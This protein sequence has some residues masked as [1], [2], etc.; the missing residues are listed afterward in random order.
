VR[1]SKSDDLI[2]L[3]INGSSAGFCLR[4]GAG[5]G[6]CNS[7][8]RRR[9]SCYSRSKWRVSGKHVGAWVDNLFPQRNK[10][11]IMVSLPLCSFCTCDMLA[12]LFGKEGIF[13]RR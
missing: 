11:V 13:Q 7:S 1:W 8:A 5:L 6:E 12:Y 4:S 9:R 10:R 2:S 3:F